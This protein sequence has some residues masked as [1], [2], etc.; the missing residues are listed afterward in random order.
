M[1]KQQVL[2]NAALREH[3]INPS[4][5]D[6]QVNHL[7]GTSE[8]MGVDVG[9]IFPSILM[10]RK[11]A[12][13]FSNKKNNIYF[14]GFLDR[15]GGRKELLEP[16]MGLPKTKIQNSFWG[17][18]PVLKR[19]NSPGYLN[20]IRRSKLVLCPMHTNWPGPK[21]KAW[22]Y[23][24]AEA[25]IFGSLPVVFEKAPLGQDFLQG[26]QY[27]E[28]SQLTLDFINDL[29]KDIYNDLVRENRE[30]AKARFF[31]SDDKILALSRVLS[32]KLGG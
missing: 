10:R 19:A 16:L 23:R 20:S 4:E 11:M 24:F 3:G 9:L 30:V 21:E 27:Y 5:C 8:V 1:L 22:S 15:K 17:R 31:L 29:D 7:S 12:T 26:F 6:I 25:V 18:L 28:A 14:S 32:C 2:L 13:S